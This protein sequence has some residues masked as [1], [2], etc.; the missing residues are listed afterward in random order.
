MQFFVRC[1]DK[2]QHLDVRMANRA[3]HLDYL[4]ALG[5]KLLIGGPTLSDDG[6]SMTG[7]MLVLD[8]PDR[9]ALDAFLAK[10]PYANAGLFEKVEVS[11]YKKVF[12]QV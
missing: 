5:D 1:I 11:V 12:P 6:Q 10:E 7:S 3:A 4:K 9:A 8:L 2:P